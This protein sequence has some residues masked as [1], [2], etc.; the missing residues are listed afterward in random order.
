MQTNQN[1]EI[2][3]SILKQHPQLYDSFSFYVKDC[4]ENK[5]EDSLDCLDRLV[6]KYSQDLKQTQIEYLNHVIN[7]ARETFYDL[8]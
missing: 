6:K 5:D 2:D 1:L 4:V 3:K 7:Q 8:K